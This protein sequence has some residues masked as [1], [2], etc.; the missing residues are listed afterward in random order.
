MEAKDCPRQKGEDLSS[1]NKKVDVSLVFQ[2]ICKKFL[3]FDP[4]HLICFV[5]YSAIV[6]FIS[7]GFLIFG[8]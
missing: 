2:T 5:I 6:N 1:T 8:K 7:R 4:L 3:K